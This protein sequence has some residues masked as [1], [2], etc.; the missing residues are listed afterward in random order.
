MEGDELWPWAQ[1]PNPI[2]LELLP[3]YITGT[4]SITKG[5]IAGTFSSAPAISLEGYHI[6]MD[7]SEEVYQIGQHTAASTSF[8]L[9]SNF[10]DTTV[11]AATFK[12]VLLEYELIP[13]NLTVTTYNNKLAFTEATAGTEL[14]ATI[15]VGVYTH[16]T[17]VTELKTQLDAAGASTYTVT[18]SAITRLYTI[19]SDLGGADN[20]F[21]ILGGTGTAANTYAS[22]LPLI[23]LAFK[24]HTGAA[25]Y[26]SENPQGSIVKLVE[27]FELHTAQSRSHKVYGLDK[28][29]FNKD[30]PISLIEEGNPTRFCVI[31]E[32]PDGYM[33]VRFNKYVKTE[34]RTEVNFIPTPLDL[35][36]TAMSGPI[37]PKEY[38]R[39]LTYGGASYLLAEKNDD[40]ASTYFT[41]A[42]EL[43]EAM[44]RNNR[45]TGERIGQHYG[46]VV[47]REDLLGFK[48]RN[49]IYGEPE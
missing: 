25:T 11:T 18:Y 15:D 44:I 19:T 40:R 32:R 3:E 37:L 4:V 6:T 41:L 38:G 35:Y 36:D 31:E 16:A 23:H 30:Y 7:G 14:T 48:R 43:L 21:S 26:V 13:T 47:A 22:I 46:E 45:K 27:P 2:T 49:L 9:K 1:T 24:N 10:V 33:K 20:I 12:A 8:T 34:A 29:R 42:K 5:T 39:I 17:L 28:L